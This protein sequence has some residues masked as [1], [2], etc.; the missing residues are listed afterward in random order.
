MRVRTGL[1]ES[2]FTIYQLSSGTVDGFFI[3][4]IEQ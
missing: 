4:K 3:P 1:T 2:D